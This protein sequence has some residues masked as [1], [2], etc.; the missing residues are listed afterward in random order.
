MPRPVPE[1]QVLLGADLSRPGGWVLAGALG[2]WGDAFIPLLDL[3][4]FLAVPT[5]TRLA[6]LAERERRLVLGTVE[7]FCRRR[8]PPCR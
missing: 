8:D 3:V 5:A 7:R 6:R 2:G 1:R 4:V